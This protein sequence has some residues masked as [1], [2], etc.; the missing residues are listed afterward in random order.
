M[1]IVNCHFWYLSSFFKINLKHLMEN[2]IVSHSCP[3]FL[4]VSLFI[5]NIQ[6]HEWV[7]FR[8]RSS[9]RRSRSRSW[10]LVGTSLRGQQAFAHCN[11]SR[12]LTLSVFAPVL[13]RNFTDYPELLPIYRRLKSFFARAFCSNLRALIKTM[14]RDAW[15][16][17]TREM[18]WIMDGGMD[19]REDCELFF[20][21]FN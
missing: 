6:F 1:P 18:S 21:N 17:V 8:G 14:H 16:I 9:R 3:Q 13:P 20:I 4:L 5:S 19:N 2:K 10:L 11:T 7:E 15:F 12:L